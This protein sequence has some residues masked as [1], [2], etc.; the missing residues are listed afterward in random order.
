MYIILAL[1]V[2]LNALANILMKVG[3]VRQ[4]ESD[5][6]L[7]VMATRALVNPALLAG[8][9]C[10]ALALIA[11]CYVLAKIN[12][13]VAYPIMTSLGY[14][15]VIVASWM[16]LKEHITLVQ[17]VGFAFIIAGVWMVAR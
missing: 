17:V 16:F 15:I 8:V 12:L 2:I 1:A 13:S 3:M 5:V 7:M 14:V 10:F 4:G 6:S 11:Y 9:T